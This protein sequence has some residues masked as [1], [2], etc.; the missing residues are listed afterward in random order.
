MSLRAPEAGAPDRR[1][2]PRRADRHAAPTPGPACPTCGGTGERVSGDFDGYVEGY[3]ICVL[4]C[5]RCTLRYSSRLD[6]PDGLYDAI[7]RHTAKLPG[8]DR[9]AGYATAVTRHPQPLDLLAS[10]ELPY[11]FVRDHVRHRL[12]P[13][14]RVVDLG[15]GEGY[16]T[17]ALRQA[18]ITC[19]G[20]DISATTVARARQRFGHEDWF[21]TTGEYAA[22]RGGRADLVIALELIEH[23]ATPTGV[24][25]DAV[26]TLGRGGC[27]LMTTPNRDASPPHEAWDTDLPPVHLLWF[28]T[29]A[30][31]ELAARAN[32]DVTFP[33][34]APGVADALRPAR[35][36]QGTWPPLLTPSG[37]LS[38]QVRRIQSVRWRARRRAARALERVVAAV[39]RSP[40]RDIPDVRRDQ[41]PGTL[42]ACFT[43]YP[44]RHTERSARTTA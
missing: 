27:V 4:E 8:Y 40:F 26:A 11:W 30:M 28:G 34:V 44:G 43:P 25:A 31:R 32:C 10:S 6:V 21:A 16:L 9:Y 18:G 38:V 3:R 29:R 2:S 33:A 37:E 1:P 20:V 23:V 22:R 19:V 7:Y 15:C 13:G 35:S 39:D 12:R 24:L 41:R 42:A 36:R 14:A 5:Q 17:Y